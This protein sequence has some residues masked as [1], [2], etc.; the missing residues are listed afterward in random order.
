MSEKMALGLLVVLTAVFVIWEAF[1]GV[2]PFADFFTLLILDE[3]IALL[4]GSGALARL[5]GLDQDD[6]QLV[7][8]DRSDSAD[9]GEE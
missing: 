7:L 9:P 5:I 2:I 4:I 6:E 3:L 8:P 1:G